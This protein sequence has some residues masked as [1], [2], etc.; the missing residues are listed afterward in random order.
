MQSIIMPV[1]YID[2]FTHFCAQAILAEAFSNCKY[3]CILF[4]SRILSI[5]PIPLTIFNESRQV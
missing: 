5:A 1:H 3:S 2:Y 4:L